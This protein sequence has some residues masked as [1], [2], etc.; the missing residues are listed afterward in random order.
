MKV[1]VIPARGGSKRIPRKN[2][3]SFLG[4]P[5][6]AWSIKVARDS[7]LF[8]RIIVSTDDDEIAGISES[9]GAEVPF[10]R[11]AEL[12]NDHTSTAP[13]IAHAIRKLEDAGYTTRY[14]CCIYPCAPTIRAAD[15]ALALQCLQADKVSFAYPVARY[16]HP[17]QR[18]MRMGATGAMAFAFPENELTRTQDLEPMFHDAGQ[19]YFGLAQAW[20]SG[21]R[22]H[23]AGIGFEIPSW[24][25]VDI[26]HEDDW[27][28]AELLVRS[29]GASG[30]CGP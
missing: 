20:L 24:R 2:I 18:A 8:D 27:T 25:V 5:M 13:V 12:A 10:R 21:A 26:D 3:K 16:A 6:I 4:R 14:A 23:T 11:P 22:M 30:P 19:F 1:A 9:L 17:I 29:Q 28:R 15:L 7:G